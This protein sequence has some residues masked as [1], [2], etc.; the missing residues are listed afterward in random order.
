[1]NA[2]RRL[3]GACGSA[4]LAGLMILAA[5]AWA[6]AWAAPYLTPGDVDLWRFL[7]PPPAAG[8]AAHDRDM[9]AVLDAQASRG[10]AEV[11]AA[12][13]DQEVD[14][15][16]FAD[17]LGPGLTGERLPKTFALGQKACRE[18]SAVAGEAKKHWQRPRPFVTNPE[19]K[20]I[21]STSA[22]RSYPSGHATCGYLWAILLGDMLP[23]QRD[24][25]FARGVR[26]GMNRVVGGVHYPTDVEAGRLGAAVIAAMMFANPAFRRDFEAGRVELRAA[27]GYA[28]NVAALP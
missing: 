13:L 6:P 4:L 17:V 14:V 1:M 18:A 15:G 7:A 23:E 27:L 24:A 20:P 26:Y 10:E 3:H 25:L 16:R 8:S 5:L 9:A 12:R 28:R 22:D 11:T 19:V 2:I 21:L